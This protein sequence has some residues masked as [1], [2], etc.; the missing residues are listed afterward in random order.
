MMNQKLVLA[1]A[2]VSV[3]FVGCGGRGGGSPSGSGSSASGSSSG[4]TASTT[5]DITTYQQLSSDTQA[6]V[7]GYRTS[8][9]DAAVHAGDCQSVHD[10]YDADV[11]SSVT[12]M[13][14]M[15]GGMDAFMD[16]HGGS[17]VVD[18]S[19]LSATMMDELDFHRSTACSFG[20]LAHDRAEVVRHTAAMTSYIGHARDRCEE[21]LGHGSWAPAM[22]GCED[23]AH[24]C[25]SGEMH[26][27]CCGG[28]TSGAAMSHTC[29]EG[30]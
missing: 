9:A 21:M 25:C 26:S 3:I 16:D 2:I 17:T 29:C 27:A 22:H 4:G 5:S 19:C 12:R 15:A 14:Q 30:G 20:D 13:V 24:T 11:R 6:A 18:V 10:R 7:D 8:M 1:V 23:W 28:M